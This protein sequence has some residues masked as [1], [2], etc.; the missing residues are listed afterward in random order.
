MF[1]SILP[2][3]AFDNYSTV[4]DAINASANGDTVII[5]PGTYV[6][7]IDFVGKAITVRSEQGHSVTAIDGNQ[8]DSVVTFA[9]GETTSSVLEGF[10]VTNGTGSLIGAYPDGGGI[11]CFGA[12]PTIRGNVI[13]GNTATYYSGGGIA[14]Y[15]SSLIIEDNVIT[16]N[17]TS[18][19]GGVACYDSP[20]P[21]IEGNTIT[22]NGAAFCG[23][24]IYCSF[25]YPAIENNLI[26]ENV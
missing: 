7:N 23:G 12:S 18:F 11:Y 19:G 3:K 17:S 16:G 15:N 4:Q 6:E 13:A 20:F 22:D 21:I 14:C 25:S 24:G 2:G 9:S 26:A 10:T 5:R 8:A 1:T